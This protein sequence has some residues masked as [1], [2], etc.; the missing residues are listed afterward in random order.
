MQFGF[1]TEVLFCEID[2]ERVV[3]VQVLFCETDGRVGCW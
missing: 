3:L 1:L 2:G